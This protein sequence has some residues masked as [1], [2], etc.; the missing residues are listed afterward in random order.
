VKHLQRWYRGMGSALH[1]RIS[2]LA[3][4]LA[5]GNYS[6]SFLADFVGVLAGR[7]LSMN[8]TF[9]GVSGEEAVPFPNCRMGRVDASGGPARKILWRRASAGIS[10]WADRLAE[11]CKS[12]WSRRM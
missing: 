9:C 1:K 7:T 12:A 10:D 2:R 11:G 3:W 6:R 5:R 8:C 4:E